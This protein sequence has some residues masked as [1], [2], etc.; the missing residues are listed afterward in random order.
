MD[1]NPIIDRLYLIC[2]S[3]LNYSCLSPLHLLI[4]CAV[5]ASLLNIHTRGSKQEKP[6]SKLVWSQIC[7]LCCAGFFCCAVSVV[8][9]K[10]LSCVLYCQDFWPWATWLYKT[11]HSAPFGRGFNCQV[12]LRVSM[13][14]LLWVWP[15]SYTHDPQPVTP[16]PPKNMVA[17]PNTYTHTMRHHITHTHHLSC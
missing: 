12:V 14:G 1:L 11:R 10:I 4:S 7:M 16:W 9:C 6:S 5:I 8:S 13:V 2:Y 15:L 3:W 17:Y